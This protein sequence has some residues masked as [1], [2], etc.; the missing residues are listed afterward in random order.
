MND[1]S[2]KPVHFL[3][4]ITVSDDDNNNNDDDAREMYAIETGEL[5]QW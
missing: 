5:A 4:E 1:E 3:R 2:E